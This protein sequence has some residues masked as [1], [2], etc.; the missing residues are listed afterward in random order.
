MRLHPL[1][2]AAA[3]LALGLIMALPA[4]AQVNS[5]NI[6]F[7]DDSGEWTHDGEC[8]DPRFSGP[9]TAEE[10]VEAD[11][12]H[13]ATD[14]R[15]AFEAGT[16][17]LSEAAADNAAPPAATAAIDFGDDTS[18]WANDGECD[19]PR[20]TG[21]GAASELL[22]EDR[23][24]DAT[25]CRTAFEAGTVTLAAEGAGGNGAHATALD[26]LAARLD[27]GDDSGEWTHD[28]EC[29]DPD[30][31]GPG[32]AGET[33]LDNRLRDASDC[34]AAFLAGTAS[35]GN[36]TADTA[37]AGFDYGDDSSQ[38]ANDGQCDDPRFEGP[39]MDKKLNFDD[40][41][42]DASDCRA[43]EASGEVS[44]IAVFAP[45]YAEGAPYD[46]SGVDF[47]DN[48]SDYADNGQCDDPRFEG[49]G[50]DSVLLESDRNA[51]ANDCRTLFEA[52]QI[53]LRSR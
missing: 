16:V 35:F 23:L 26:R 14:C 34:R 25:D 33:S 18:T 3:S 49:P 27:F 36:A 46:S 13:D 50:S 9:G 21:A 1:S 28:G 41:R 7:G 47:G 43:L 31:F 39:G 15:A 40:A 29:D 4:L 51:D 44:I 52:G 8:D 6:D 10:L 19:D 48:S 20:F 5:Q 17:T 30:F 53:A 37:A 2:V 45:A 42:A 24:R 38:W 22:D 11:R 32:V 12:L